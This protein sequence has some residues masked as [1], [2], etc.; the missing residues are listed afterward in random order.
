MSCLVEEQSVKEWSKNGLSVS[1]MVIHHLKMKKEED[2]AQISMTKDAV[3]EDESLT[4]QILA[5]MI[6]LGL[7]LKHE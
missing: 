3:E 2:A 6:T 1:R 7:T 5:E 4:T